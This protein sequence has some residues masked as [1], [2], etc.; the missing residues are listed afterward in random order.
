[1]TSRHS[2]AAVIL[3]SLSVLGCGWVDNAGDNGARKNTVLVA[4]GNVLVADG[5]IALIEDSATR[6]LLTN[7]PDVSTGWTWRATN[8]TDAINL[9]RQQPNF[10]SDVAVNSLNAACSAGSDCKFGIEEISD[11]GS[12]SFNLTLPTLRAPVALSYEIEATL[13]SGNRYSQTQTVCGI[14]INEAPET[15]DD[16]YRALTS[17][18]RVVNANDAWSI[19][20]N[21]S[22]DDHVRNQ[23]LFI[24]Q[25]TR[26][27]TYADA[28]ELLSDG[29]FRYTARA[30][31]D[32][33]DDASLEDSMEILI[34]DGVHDVISAISIRLENTNTSPFAIDGFTDVIVPVNDGVA[35][36]LFVDFNDFF[37][38]NDNDSLRYQLIG[39]SLTE[40][41]ILNFNE[42]GILSGTLTLDNVGREQFTLLV[43]DGLF[44]LSETFTLEVRDDRAINSEPETDNI[45]NARVSG[46]FSYNV[47]DFFK[48]ADGDTLSFSSENLPPD[49]TLSRDGLI[50][51]NATANNDGRWLIRITA[52]DNRGGTVV[53][54]FRMTIDFN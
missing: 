5:S 29:S 42:S 13:A 35:S 37:I 53:D 27:P 22:D 31:L 46:S 8:I 52:S 51:G 38:N 4:A 11:S 20:S 9:C 19:F 50:T 7:A 15:Q 28:V 2:V 3:I 30:D 10:D 34:S 21:D 54:R 18:P 45:P 32:L 49:V 36:E 44:E 33:D 1:M 24:K 14:A 16:F 40:A 26:S 23:P 43:T 17:T 48:D 41:G 12:T 47:A 6:F 39:N 25:I